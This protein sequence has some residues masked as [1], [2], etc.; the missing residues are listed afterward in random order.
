MRKWRV[1]GRIYGMKYSWKGRKDEKQT[2][3]E[4]KKEWGKLGWFIPKTQTATSAPC[5]NAPMRSHEKGFEGRR[6]W[7]LVLLVHSAPN[8]GSRGGRGLTEPWGSAGGST[9]WSMTRAAGLVAPA[10][11]IMMRLCLS[12]C[13]KTYRWIDW[14][15]EES[16]YEKQKV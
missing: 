1:V 14:T 4:S 9:P 5:E 11:T 2:Q 7:T 10:S 13:V 6:E 15:A 16:N 3:E 8:L 12:T